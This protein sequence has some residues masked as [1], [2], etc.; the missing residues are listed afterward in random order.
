MKPKL[1]MAALLVA[2]LAGLASAGWWWYERQ[3]RAASDSLVLHGNVDIREVQLAFNASDRIEQVLVRE[4]ERVTAGQLLA[5]LDSRKLR[6]AVDEAQ[7]QVAAQREVVARFVAGSRPEEIRK[8]RADVEAA[9]AD[10]VNAEQTY[11]RTVELVAQNFVAQQQADNAKG[12]LDAAQARLKSAEETLRLAVVGPRKED[13]AAAKATLAAYEAALEIAQRNLA[14][15]SL[16]A[17]A[18]GVIENRVLEPGDMASPQ[19]T[20]FT[21]ALTDPLWVRAYV[22]E[23]DLGRLR[24]GAVAQIMT[25]SYPG[26]RYRGWI[27]FISPTA[28]F[29][30]KSVETQEVRTALVYQVRVFACPPHEELRL[31]MPATVTVA[32]GSTQTSSGQDVCKSSP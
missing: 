27:G 12:T 17:P 16:Y 7:A 18:E 2:L 32:L 19:R 4:G 31:G 22:P 13:I 30:P 8:A 15:A 28:E 29:T 5:V 11:R 6:H 24:L 10:A 21:L 26:K 25:D 3:H 23:P 1:V 9:R 20:V 14:E